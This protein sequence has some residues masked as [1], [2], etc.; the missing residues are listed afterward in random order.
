[1]VQNVNPTFV[2]TPNR[3]L[4]SLT[5]GTGSSGLV[6][7]YTAGTNGSKIVGLWAAGTSTA[8]QDLQWGITNAATFFLMGT[9]SIPAGAGSTDSIPAVN[10]FSTTAVPGMPL[11]SD[12]NYY[13]LLASTADTLQAKSPT[14][15]PTTGGVITVTAIS[16][17]F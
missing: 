1:M 9:V 2:K 6:T 8:A 16:G 10:L 13:L 15:I 3:G 17:D 5:T 4:I 11:D 7:V 14:L 12:G